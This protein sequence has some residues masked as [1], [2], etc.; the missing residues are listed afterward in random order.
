VTTTEDVLLHLLRTVSFYEKRVTDLE[1][2]LSE[3]QKKIVECQTLNAALN[4]ELN[5][6]K[7]LKKIGE[8]QSLAN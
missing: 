4:A 2:Q 3:A 6:P 7:L 5:A 1:A 8:T